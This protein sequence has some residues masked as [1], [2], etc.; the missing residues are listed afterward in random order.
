MTKINVYFPNKICVFSVY[1]CIVLGS[2]MRE[3]SKE[4]IFYQ[5]EGYK[6]VWLGYCSWHARGW[7]VVYTQKKHK[8][9]QFTTRARIRSDQIVVST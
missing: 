6:G 5:L 1:D 3:R 7:L 4:S 9:K 2:R 8:G